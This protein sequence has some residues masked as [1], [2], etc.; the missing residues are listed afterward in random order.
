MSNL[1]FRAWNFATET[2]VDLKVITPF[3]L[4]PKLNQDGV[5]IPFGEEYAIMQWTGINDSK[6][7][8][9]YDGD[10][11]LFK[12]KNKQKPVKR[13][14]NYVFWD[15]EKLRWML[16][17]IPQVTGMPEKCPLHVRMSTIHGGK[18]I[19]VGNLYKNAK[20]VYQLKEGLPITEDA[21]NG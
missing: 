13:P 3:A 20:F 16:G 15:E 1:R 19:V 7:T 17:I 6:G 14:Y 11:V 18:Y 12:P 5:F 8:P 4:D 10:L 2:M 9:I 21:P